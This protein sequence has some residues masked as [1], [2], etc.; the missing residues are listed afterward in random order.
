MTTVQLAIHDGDFVSAVSALLVAEGQFTVLVVD[1]PDPKIPGLM[2][3]SAD[4]LES[5]RPE[6]AARVVVIARDPEPRDPSGLWDAGIRYVIFPEGSAE[7]ACMAILAANLRLLSDP[8]CSILDGEG[9]IDLHENGLH[10]PFA[11]TDSTIDE[12]I[13][14]QSPGAFVLDASDE[15]SV[16]RARFVGR[17]DLDVNNQLHVHVG[18]YKRFKFVYCPSAQAAFEKECALFHDFEPTDNVTHPRRPR[19]SRWA[20]PHCRF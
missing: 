16:F 17:S 3:I 6:D 12:V 11:L 8:N 10:G 4:L 19:G 2:V 5:I 18:S 1:Q 13:R 9:V 7:S 20:C 14:E 15:G